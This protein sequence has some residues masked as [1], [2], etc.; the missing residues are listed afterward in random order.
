MTPA[1]HAHWEPRNERCCHCLKRTLLP[2]LLQFSP[3][4][5]YPPVPSSRIRW[6]RVT[7]LTFHR[8]RHPE[9]HRLRPPDPAFPAPTGASFSRVPF[10]PIRHP[11]TVTISLK[12]AVAV[13]DEVAIQFILRDFKKLPSICQIYPVFVSWPLCRYSPARTKPSDSIT[14]PGGSGI[15]QPFLTVPVPSFTLHNRLTSASYYHSNRG[16]VSLSARVENDD[17]ITRP[18]ANVRL[19]RP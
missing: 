3:M 5:H 17:C 9:I 12:R 14:L 2:C 4:V 10:H 6:C 18:S 1:I 11:D 13:P 16:Y 15:R 8:F 19:P 7:L